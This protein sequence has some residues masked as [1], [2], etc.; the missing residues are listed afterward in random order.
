MSSFTSI[1]LQFH[2]EVPRRVIYEALTDQMYLQ[3]LYRKVMQYTRAP[4]QVRN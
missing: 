2:F 1:N 4:A 3:S